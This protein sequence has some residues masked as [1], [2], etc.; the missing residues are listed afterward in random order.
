MRFEYQWTEIS[1]VAWLTSELSSRLAD[2]I[3]AT[4]RKETEESIQ[5]ICSLIGNGIRSR[6]FQRA[7]VVGFQGDPDFARKINYEFM[8]GY[9]MW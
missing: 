9:F 4:D 5:K 8:Y 6:T 1:G 2:E 3:R 7:T